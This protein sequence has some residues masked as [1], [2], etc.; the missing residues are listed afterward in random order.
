M[1]EPAKPFIFL[2][3]LCGLSFSQQN[4]AGFPKLSGPYL[5]QKPPGDQA[6]LFAPGI[7][8]TG[9]FE[10]SS[11]VFTPDLKEIYWSTQ[12]Y[13]ENGAP[14]LRPILFMKE[15]NG[16]WSQPE[17]P[18]FAKEFGC[19]DSPFTS[20]DGRKLFFHASDTIR[21]VK[22]ALYYVER[23]GDGWSAKVKMGEP[24]NATRWNGEPTVSKNG[25]LYFYG[26]YRADMGIYYSRLVDGRYQKPVPMEEKF[27]SLQTDWT[28]YIAPDEN[29]FIFCSFR[30][31]G[32][33]SGD[34]YISFRQEDGS[35]GKVINMGDRINGPLNER[36]PNVT[37]DGKYLFFNSTRKIT[38]AAANAPG[39]GNGDVYWIDAKIIEELRK[40]ASKG[41]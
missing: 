24:I 5:G 25:T 16:V 34:L 39:N 27:N 15:V 21:P 37:P 14:T 10:H 35:W 7:V 26:D 31:G 23:A 2:V 38:C 20:P 28:P 8:S 40:A 41:Q 29:Y 4:Q 6:Q 17:I 22:A 3:A 12:I 33:G 13:D 18:S 32:F 19:S 11:P 9:Y 36:F 30:P 1:R